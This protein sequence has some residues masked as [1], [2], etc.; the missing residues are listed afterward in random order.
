MTDLDLEGSRRLYSYSEIEAAYTRGQEDLKNILI[1]HL[2]KLF[3]TE[4][5]YKRLDGLVYDE[6]ADEWGIALPELLDLI[7]E[8]S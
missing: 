2:E 3:S 1:Y 4:N 5:L 7:R 8:K 6:V